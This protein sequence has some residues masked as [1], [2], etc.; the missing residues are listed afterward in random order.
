M[1]EKVEVCR[2]NARGII[3]VGGN[4]GAAKLLYSWG[5]ISET[6]SWKMMDI[7]LTRV[8]DKSS[9][10]SLMLRNFIAI[11]FY[12]EGFVW[13]LRRYVVT[14][15]FYLK[16]STLVKVFVSYFWS[17]NRDEYVFSSYRIPFPLLVTIRSRNSSV[18]LQRRRDDQISYLHILS[19][20]F[21][22]CGTFVKGSGLSE[23]MQII[24]ISFLSN[25]IYFSHYSSSFSE[26]LSRTLF[27]LTQSM[28]DG[29]TLSPQSS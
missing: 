15:I 25:R 9:S 17:K 18:W 1:L 20:P 4:F 8:G 3:V 26:S 10:F 24:A 6:I 21:A 22:S 23:D 14:T 13:V 28:V 7:L 27:N 2:V 12:V 19:F 5:S 16:R 29:N 11:Y